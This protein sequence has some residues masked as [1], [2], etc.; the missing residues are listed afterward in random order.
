[1]NR[2]ARKIAWRYLFSKKSHSAINAI[3]IVSVCGVAI[4]TLALVCT[5]SVYNGFTELIGSLYSQID[6]QI[7]ITP[8]QGK[9]LDTEEE[10]IE[11]I[12]EW[13]EVKTF[14]PVIEEN[15]LCIYKDRQRPV[16][17]KGVPDN[18][19]E[20]SH[21]QDIVTSGT[22]QRRQNRLRII[23]YRRS[24]TTRRCRQLPLSGRIVR[25]QSV[26]KSQSD[27]SVTVVQRET[28]FRLID[29]LRQPSHL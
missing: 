10:T 21:I 26:G 16:L 5:L 2:L 13:N 29:I 11:Q 20:L 23:R 6:P 24:W 1:M 17:V 3:S 12:A 15:A 18:Y 25:S 14:T 27:Q 4:T 9:T 22:F 19:T 28:Y 8:L 7:K